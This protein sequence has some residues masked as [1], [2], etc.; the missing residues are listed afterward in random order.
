MSRSKLLGQIWK[1]ILVLQ[2][3]ALCFIYFKPL[4][5]HAVLL[6]EGAEGVKWE[7]DLS[8][9]ALGKWDLGH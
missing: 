6:R 3:H 9:V 5:F 8:F 1:K 2:E 4:S 7:L